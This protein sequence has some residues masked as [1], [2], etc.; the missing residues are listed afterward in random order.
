MPGSDEKLFAKLAVAAGHI[1]REQ[2]EECLQIQESSAGNKTLWEIMVDRSYLDVHTTNTIL[3]KVEQ[4]LA[5]RRTAGRQKVE[6]F[7]GDIAVSRGYCSAEQMDRAIAEQKSRMEGGRNQRLGE[8]CV[9]MGVL[10][11]EQVALV[12]NEQNRSI[13]VCEGC[14]A[15]Y[16]V[17]GFPAGKRWRCRAC[18]DSPPCPSTSFSQSRLSEAGAKKSPQALPGRPLRPPGLGRGPRRR[19]SAT[20]TSSRRSPREAWA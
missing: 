11:A 9:E 3:E 18:R 8:L 6:K 12:L 7:F 19:D 14:G 4:Q 10:T 15:A 13:L 17:E 2:L 5:A 20:T 1:T 16:S